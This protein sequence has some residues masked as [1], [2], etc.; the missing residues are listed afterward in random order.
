MEKSM[1][2][3][4]IELLSDGKAHDLMEIINYLQLDLSDDELVIKTLNKLVDNYDVYCTK[5]GRYMLFSASDLSETFVK[6][7]FI[8]TNN[9]YGFVEI[10]KNSDDIFIHGSKTN[11]ALDGDLVLVRI[12]KSSRAERKSEGEIFKVLKHEIKNKVG[13]VYHYQNKLMVQLDDK[14]YKKL[15]VLKGHSDELNRLVDGDKVLVSFTGQKAKDNYIEAQLVKRIGHIND[16]GID[17]SSI[18]VEHGFNISFDEKI[19]RELK[20]IP[21]CLTERDLIDRRDLRQEMIFTIDGDDT[22]DIDDAISVKRLDNGNWHLGVHI[23]D[24]SYY[25]K[26]NTAL[27]LEARMRSTSVYVAN[28]VEPMFPHQLSNGICSLNPNVDRLAISCEMEIDN[29]GNLVNYEIFPSVIRSN[30]QMTYN[31]VNELLEK[32]IVPE[33]YDPYKKML[34][35]MQNLSQII[36]NNKVKR[37]CIDFDTD[38][39]KIVVDSNGDVLDITKR[40]RGVGEKMIEDFMIMANECVASHLFYMDL[41]S[42]YRVHGLPD[43]ARLIKFLNLLNS[44]GINIKADTKKMKPKVIQMIIN[45]LKKYPEYR[46]LCTRL[47]GCMDKA[48]YDINNIGHFGIASKCYTHFTSPIRRY[49]DLIIHRLLRNYFFMKDGIT[50]EKIRHFKEILSEIAIHSS[51]RERASDDCEREGLKMKMAEYMENNI[52]EEYKGMISGVTNFGFFVQLDNLVEGL[53]PILSFDEVY[54]YD[55]RLEALIGERSH[56]IFRLG[57]EVIVR[58]EKASKEERQIDFSL[59]KRV[60]VN[61][62]EKVKAKY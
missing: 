12:T 6:G 41:P 54:Q 26:E 53:V 20:A 44:L 31:K 40:S 55:E 28:T 33:G 27:D 25:V 15:I 10:D 48:I 21:T 5:K 50:D 42:L 1:E 62:K 46:V 39:A 61:E 17:I 32:N 29:K 58:V 22:K 60:D 51:E 11:G 49:P 24:V 19:Q 8:D 52:G 56:N 18:L 38:E 13:E 36:R 30:I 47:L 4:I 16:P 57:Q 2:K 14:A 59:V 45:E 3:K 23:A 35:D 43:E 9:D 7:R 34:R 37:G